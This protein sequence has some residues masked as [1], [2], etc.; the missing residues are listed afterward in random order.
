MESEFVLA[1]KVQSDRIEYQISVIAT[2]NSPSIT[3]LANPDKIDLR[4]T[5]YASCVPDSVR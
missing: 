5:L 2:L 3:P 1:G 4:Y